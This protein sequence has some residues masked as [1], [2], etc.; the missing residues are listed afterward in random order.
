MIASAR[1]NQRRGI[2]FWSI[3]AWERLG[4]RAVF[5]QR[6][7]G[8]SQPPYKGLNLGIATSDAI[9]TVKQ[10]RGLA[11]KAARLGPYLPVMGQQVHGQKIVLVN[12]RK[13][14][15]GWLEAETALTETDGLITREKGMPIGVAVADCLP[16]L[17][18]SSGKRRAVA[19][20]HAGWR[21]LAQGIVSL[22]VRRFQEQWGI[23]PQDIRAAIGPG[24]GPDHFII[25]GEVLKALQSQYPEAVAVSQRFEPAASFNLGQ[26]AQIQLAHAGILPRHIT[27]IPE[28][29]ACHPKKYFSYRRDG[30]ETGRMLGMVQIK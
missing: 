24:I 14:G 4:Y 8:V 25:Q 15:C 18:V 11:L 9:G 7:G 6:Q 1:F 17:L 10:N 5:F 28:C 27:V 16:V 3:P 20:L 12:R 21:G 19:A 23:K 22:G 29:T 26:A 30:K 13:Q 2:N